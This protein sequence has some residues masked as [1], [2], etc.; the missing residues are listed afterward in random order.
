MELRDEFVAFVKARNPK[1]APLAELLTLEYTKSVAARAL[2]DASS[3][4]TS[5]VEKLKELLTAFLD[6]IANP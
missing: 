1:L 5:W 6:T 2:G 3:T 4:I